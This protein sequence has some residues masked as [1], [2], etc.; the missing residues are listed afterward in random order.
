MKKAHDFIVY[1]LSHAKRES[2]P[3]GAVLPID[4]EE[5]GI[6]PWEYLYGTTGHAVTKELIEERYE[7]FYKKKGWTRESYDTAT[8]NWPELKRKAT[9]C[10]GLLDSFLGTDVTANYCY[11]AWCTERGSVDEVERPYEI[12][13]ALFYMNSE[14]RMTHVGFVC[15]FLEGEPVAVEAR[16]IRFGVVVTRF[17][18]RPWTHRGLVTKMLSYDEEMRDEPL[19]LSLTRPMIQGEH[20]LHLQKALNALG[21]YCGT[22]D[23]KCGRITLSG[24]REFVSRH[25][26]V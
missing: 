21:Y 9:D 4:R 25:A 23:G 20:I 10:Q 12:G 22:P 13:E 7:H 11:T 17:S 8:E 14:G 15:G 19:V 18:E 2:I 6:E 5:C 16:G 26:A 3:E 24:V 1:A